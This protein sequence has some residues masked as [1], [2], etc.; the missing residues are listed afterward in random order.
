MSS[1][2]DIQRQA[3]FLDEGNLKKELET[4]IVTSFAIDNLI[5]IT[6]RDLSYYR[7]QYDESIRVIDLISDRREKLKEQ[8]KLSNRITRLVTRSVDYVV[9]TVTFIKDVV[10]TTVT[11]FADADYSSLKK[12]FKSIYE[13]LI[14]EVAGLNIAYLV[15]SF[16]FLFD[17]IDET[18]GIVAVQL[19]GLGLGQVGVYISKIG[20][21]LVDVVNKLCSDTVKMAVQIGA[22]IVGAV[23]G[24]VVAGVKTGG[25]GVKAGVK[26]GAVS[27]KFFAEM[28]DLACM[29]AVPMSYIIE[30]RL[31]T[32]EDEVNNKNMSELNALKKEVTTIS[33]QSSQK[34]ETLESEYSHL[35]NKK[36]F[37][38]TSMKIGISL[39]A[40]LS[41]I[42]NEYPFIT[43]KQLF[44]SFMSDI[45][46]QFLI[47][48]KEKLDASEL[49]Y[50]IHIIRVGIEEYRS[51]VPFKC[52]ISGELVREVSMV[53]GIPK[54]RV[55]I[56]LSS[57]QLKEISSKISDK[58][59][60]VRSFIEYNNIDAF[61]RE[62]IGLIAEKMRIIKELKEKE[63]TLF[64]NIMDTKNINLLKSYLHPKKNIISSSIINAQRL[65]KSS[66]IF[67][68]ALIG[69][70]GAYGINK[71]VRS[72]VKSQ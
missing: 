37:I 19:E 24:G 62:N 20:D 52:F 3:L 39:S 51:K 42:I 9:E 33:E 55:C 38:N 23:V 49:Y 32:I 43:K 12:F 30:R 17:Q 11:A 27:G 44:D 36:K 7:N 25:A 22:P 63:P 68:Y 65:K 47:K 48:N 21:L 8:E 41:T 61:L 71:L 58:T 29:T 26:G 64:M 53:T 59:N 10:V 6:R 2:T 50:I 34:I 57:Q 56:E 70:I 46:Y 66:S 5:N 18:L 13:N 28:Y 4:L 1:S 45:G 15:D 72:R 35:M 60:P 69:I 16:V 54:D 14:K 31:Q 67:I 40:Y